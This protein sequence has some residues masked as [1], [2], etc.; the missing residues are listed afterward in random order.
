MVIGKEFCKRF[1]SF[2][3]FRVESQVRDIHLYPLVVVEPVPDLWL[4]GTSASVEHAK[5]QPG[6]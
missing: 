2:L 4:V 5:K 3:L 6:R 1:I